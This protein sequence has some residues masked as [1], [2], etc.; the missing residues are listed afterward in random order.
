MRFVM[1]S[2]NAQRLVVSLAFT[3]FATAALAHACL[4][5][6]EPAV[7]GVVTTS[8]A[9]IRL[10]FSEGVAPRLSGIDLT[11]AVGGVE[12][13]SSPSVDPADSSVLIAKVRQT[14]PQGVYEDAWRA[15][16]V[17]AHRPQSG[18]RFTI[19]P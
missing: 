7:S 9:E 3:A 13:T 16:S 4:Q 10:R 18:F 14:L 12:A 8:P 2:L 5:T 6:A 15:V 17:D 1:S 19:K 11:T